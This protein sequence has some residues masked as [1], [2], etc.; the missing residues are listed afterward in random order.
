MKLAGARR[1]AGEKSFHAEQVTV[2]LL[3]I[4]AAATLLGAYLLFPSR[5]PPRRGYALYLAVEYDEKTDNRP[6]VEVEI[7]HDESGTASIEVGFY[8]YDAEN[9]APFELTVYREPAPGKTNTYGFTLKP[10]WHHD[11]TTGSFITLPGPANWV[12]K[13]KF[14]GREMAGFTNNGETILGVLAAVRA[15]GHGGEDD[16][17]R[18]NTATSF[19]TPEAGT[20][21]EWSGRTPVFRF[22]D[23]VGFAVLANEEISSEEQLQVTGFNPSASQSDSHNLFFAGALVGLAGGAVTAVIPE[24]MKLVADRR[25]SKGLSR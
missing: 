20:L 15:Y 21:Y 19:V 14:T 7:T 5:E 1:R 6:N 24:T 16:G 17:D 10:E 18:L 8:V 11:E 25:G 4:I 12:A 3:L 23:Y 13:A 22:A 2:A 9:P